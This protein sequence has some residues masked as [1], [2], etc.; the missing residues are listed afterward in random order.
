MNVRVTMTMLLDMLSAHDRTALRSP[1]VFLHH[2]CE[3]VGLE[4]VA[5]QRD[6]E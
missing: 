5:S 3:L 6:E 1:I 2:R 4:I